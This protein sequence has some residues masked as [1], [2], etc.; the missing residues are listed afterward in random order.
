[1]LFLVTYLLFGHFVLLHPDGKAIQK[2][3]RELPHLYFNPARRNHQL[4]CVEAFIQV[5]NVLVAFTTQWYCSQG[6]IQT[7]IDT[8]TRTRTRT[9]IHKETAV[10]AWSHPY[11]VNQHWDTCVLLRCCETAWE[12]YHGARLVRCMC[13][14]GLALSLL[15]THQ[16]RV[17]LK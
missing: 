13:V 1:M 6:C 14:Y 3:C 7:N 17:F 9:H 11:S 8:H 5:S 2:L 15:C 12:N 4:N 10:L 16:V